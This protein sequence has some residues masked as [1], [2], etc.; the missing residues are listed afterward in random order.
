M[1]GP[2]S[3]RALGGRGT[4]KASPLTIVFELQ[5]SFSGFFDAG[6]LIVVPRPG[7]CPACGHGR[8]VFDGWRPRQTRRGRVWLQ[9][10]LCRGPDC[11]QRSH[12]LCPDV[13]VAGRVDL[14]RVIGWALE[15][16]AAGVGYRPIAGVLGVP[17]STVRGWLRQARR[18]GQRVA[19]V[20][21][22]W[23]AAADPG[24]RGPPGGSGVAV[25]VAASHLAADALFRLSGEPQDRWLVAVTAT[26]GRLLG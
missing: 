19:G 5:V 24:M 11:P 1:N 21:W 16:A 20:L 8:L 6:G 25:L 4:D 2:R 26:G 7:V 22:G 14:A 23:A 9:R 17:A 10:V 13:L 3:V 18:A 12:S 15:Q